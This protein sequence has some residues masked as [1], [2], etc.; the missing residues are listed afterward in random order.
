[1]PRLPIAELDTDGLYLAGP[2]STLLP[3]T[4][5]FAEELTNPLA[6]RL[7]GPEGLADRLQR[8]G[9]RLMRST[10]ARVGTTIGVPTNF[11][12]SLKD[13]VAAVVSGDPRAIVFEG[14]RVFLDVYLQA[15]GAIPFVGVVARLGLSIVEGVLDA[16]EHGRPLPPAL[17]Y[18][19]ELNADYTQELMRVIGEPGQFIADW[20]DVFRPT[21][22]GA[23]EVVEREDEWTW[24]PAGAGTDGWGIVPGIPR[25]TMGIVASH[26]SLSAFVAATGK[27]GNRKGA[28]RYG[29]GWVYDKTR[30]YP[31]YVR[32]GMSAWEALQTK[33]AAM[34]NVDTRGVGH[35]WVQYVDGF[36][37][38]R[39]ADMGDIMT[40]DYA[41]PHELAAYFAA[42]GVY[43]VPTYAEKTGRFAGGGKPT[44]PMPKPKGASTA[45]LPYERRIDY[46]ARRQLATLR[47]RQRDALD[48]LL[49]AYCSKDQAAFR[50][51]ELADL[52]RHRRGQLLD[53]PALADVD[54]ADVVD[55]DYRAE[56]SAALAD[57]RFGI[58]GLAAAPPVGSP[59]VFPGP[60]GA[61]G[62]SPWDVPELDDDAGAAAGLLVVGGLGLGLG[63]LGLYRYLRRRARR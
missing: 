15:M 12:P 62:G 61:P 28:Y 46:I 16:A 25:G 4:A 9:T 21:R 27:G 3:P 19:A 33:T 63:G 38:R 58:G 53:H 23:W 57:K 54:L 39:E 31:S 20:T 49:V 59:A 17:T 11:V 48:T 26:V 24:E 44:W 35:E 40:D 1:M 10:M 42:F 56:V 29:T 55:D 5:A 41:H 34:F 47:Q 8:E 36:L 22:V 37:E 45:T 18:N 2:F 51:D 32:A 6:E 60:D 43:D 13:A 52:L 14:A 50:D 7:Y 30:F